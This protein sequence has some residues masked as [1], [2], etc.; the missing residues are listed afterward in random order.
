M[1]TDVEASFSRWWSVDPA[2]TVEVRYPHSRHGNEGKT[3]HTAKTEVM[4][5][6]LKFVN[7]NSQP[8]GRSADSSGPTFFFLP[9]FG[10]IQTPKPNVTN[11]E[12]RVKRSVV[13]EFNRT[14][15]ELGKCSNASSHN[16]L[17]QRPK[18]SIC[19]HQAD[20]C[21][22]S[23]RNV[24]IHSKQTIVNCLL[25]SSNATPEEVMTIEDEIKSLKPS[26][27]NH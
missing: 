10:T 18:V 22:T 6:F 17:K 1:P 21:D 27:E 7:M 23:K 24:E 8:N 9:K 12:E 2:S 13:G 14:Q 20:Y 26:L 15:R 4:E 5:H 19:S 25:Q 3:S 16:W 11:F